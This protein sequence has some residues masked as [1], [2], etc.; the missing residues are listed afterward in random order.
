MLHSWMEMKSDSIISLLDVAIRSVGQVHRIS[1]RQTLTW[2][3]NALGC[4]LLHAH[5][6]RNFQTLPPKVSLLFL[7]MTITYIIKYDT[8]VSW[9][10]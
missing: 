10:F 5:Y 1:P 6:V 2:V 8:K 7:E 9:T 3:H 4:S